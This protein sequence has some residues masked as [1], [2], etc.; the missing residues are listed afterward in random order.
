[1]KKN[2]FL[3]VS[4][5]VIV[6]VVILG[7]TLNKI[8]QKEKALED[9]KEEL[10]HTKNQIN[11]T[12]LENKQLLAKVSSLNNELLSI[13]NMLSTAQKQSTETQKPNEEDISVTQSTKSKAEEFLEALSSGTSVD[14]RVL[15]MKKFGKVIA[16]MTKTPDI[17]MNLMNDPEIRNPLMEV[18]NLIFGLEINV[19]EISVLLPEIRPFLLN[20]LSGMLEESGKQPLSKEQIMQ[21][22]SVFTRMAE[23]DKKITQGMQ[24]HIEKT[25]ARL[26]NAETFN[27]KEL[28]TI[29]TE[30]QK[31]VLEKISKTLD[32]NN[33]YIVYING[34]NLSSPQT[35]LS[36]QLT[37]V[38]SDIQYD[39]KDQNKTSQQV[40][41]NWAKE[42][43]ASPEQ[44]NSLKPITEQ[45]IKDYTELRKRMETTYDKN[46]MDYY[47]ERNKPEDED[48][49]EEYYRE[50]KK[51]FQTNPDYDRAKTSL[52]L[53]FLELHYNYLKQVSETVGHEKGAKILNG[54][55][56]IVHYPNVE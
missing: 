39:F 3:I 45:Y 21:Y 41:N 23:L 54:P 7:I 43:H 15:K 30:E 22:E 56:A 46:I 29:L 11:N 42:L 12:T 13:K 36:P 20:I 26:Q 48:K 44:K 47:L 17:D 28:S 10:Q 27:S 4:G 25:I 14:E 53:K 19:D 2:V 8:W 35:V 18:V 24:T 34:L 1:M 6:F 52:D 50:R 16:Q 32:D 40:L 9:A 51:L 49:Q 38:E 55:P 31:E 33:L 5:I 37:N